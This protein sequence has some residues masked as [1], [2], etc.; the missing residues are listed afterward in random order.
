MSN[1]EL[2]TCHEVMRL[3]G[4]R[5]RT[6]IWRRIRRGAFPQ[7]IDLGGGRIRWRPV[8]SIHTPRTCAS[9]ISA[10]LTGCG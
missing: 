6:T 5:S 1:I 8:I 10:G 4:I 9:R 3:T 7:P 2:L